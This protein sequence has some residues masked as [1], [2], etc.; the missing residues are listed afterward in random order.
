MRV[1]LL[2]ALVSF[3]LFAQKTSIAIA[4]SLYYYGNYTKAIDRLELHTNK[5]ESYPKIAANYLALGNTSKAISFYEKALEIEPDNQ[6]NQYQLAKLFSTNKFYKKAKDLFLSLIDADYKNPNYHYQLGKVH[7]ALNDEFSAQSRFK[8]AYDLDKTHL[9]PIYELAKYALK[10]GHNKTFNTYV[11]TGLKADANYKGLISLKAQYLFLKKDY[12]QALI[13]FEKL[14]QL[15]ENTQFVNEKISD[16]YRM[17]YQHKQGINYLKKALNFDKGNINYLFSLGRLHQKLDEFKAAESYY[18]TAL[19]LRDR[20]LKSEYMDLGIVLNRQ[21]KYPE[22]IKA[23]KNAL[24]FSP[25]NARIYFY[26]VNSKLEYYEDHQSKIDE[27]KKFQKRFPDNPFNKILD[28][29]L[30]ELISED[31]HKKEW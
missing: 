8:S 29:K 13:Q 4:D 14:V 31:F 21:K 1:F 24:R 10:K 19:E 30:K 28:H 22:A 9:K 3:N 6:L 15:N 17:L 16:C 12:K 11:E 5:G 23:F 25:N 26:M 7:K 2:L 18:V 20:S 27:I